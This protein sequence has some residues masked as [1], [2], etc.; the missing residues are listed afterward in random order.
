MSR[1]RYLRCLAFL[2]TVLSLLGVR[3]ASADVPDV[4]F[5]IFRLD[6]LTYSVK[7]VYQETQPYHRVLAPPGA[8]Q[9]GNVYLQ[10]KPAGDFGYTKIYSRITGQL[11]VYA[12]TIWMGRGGLIEPP[13]ASFTHDFEHGHVAPDPTSILDSSSGWKDPDPAWAAVKDTDVIERLGALGDYEVVIY[14]HFYTVGLSDP[15]TAEWFVIAF[16]HP[17]APRDV[18]ITSVVWP[19]TIVTRGVPTTPEIVVHNFSDGP[20]SPVV[21]GRAENGSG[22]VYD[23]SVPTGEIPP[24]SSVTLLLPSWVA[25]TL[26]SH[27]LTI[28]LRQGQGDPWS[29]TFNDNDQQSKTCNV[30][31]LPVFRQRP[32][33]LTAGGNPGGIPLDLDGD[34]DMDYFHVDYDT[35][36]YRNDGAQGFTDITSRFPPIQHW[37]HEA[38]ASDLNGDG[39][40]ELLVSDLY[41]GPPLLFSDAGSGVYSDIT[42]TAGLGGLDNHG[43]G[44]LLDADQDGDADLVLAH[45]LGTPGQ[46]EIVLFKNDGGHFSRLQDSGLEAH[47]AQLA[48]IVPAD[49]NHDGYP[50]LVLANW[51]SPSEVF[52]NDGTGHFSV[53][54]GPWTAVTYGRSALVFDPDL[55]GDLDILLLARY[56]SATSRYF[57]NKGGFAFVDATEAFGDLVPAFGGRVGDVDGNG[58]PDVI[59]Q[60]DKSLLL[61]EG[62]HFTAHGE[63]IIGAGLGYPIYVLD[64]DADGDLDIA[65]E[66]G[67]YLEN[68]GADPTYRAVGVHL[69]SL[70]AR[71]EGGEAVVEWSLAED[72][73]A[74]DFQV[75]RSTLSAPE[76][77]SISGIL[78]GGKRAYEFVDRNA[79]PE[80]TDYWIAEVTRTGG[81]NWFGPV[82]VEV[83]G[84]TRLSLSQ[85]SPNP[86][87]LATRIVF[88]LPERMAV[89]LSVYNVEGRK[90]RDLADQVFPPGETA[91]YWDGRDEQGRTTSSGIYY[92]RLDA[93]RQSFTHRMIKIS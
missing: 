89:K 87:G 4:H 92:Y 46:M 79:P 22:V 23:V 85:N 18:G 75:Y 13:V 86:F 9:L 20:E 15:T 28:S 24:D 73:Y 39:F 69:T 36:I 55:D 25:P 76:K 6:F 88:S 78:T 65:Y 5:A 44:R 66:R 77:R 50:D 42:S 70:T 91:V 16:T 2:L 48:N 10:V 21:N 68:L 27:T 93:G 34:G 1:H 83:A 74:S 7:G 19:Q 33:S 56:V 60:D 52:R 32:P 59:L 62:G 8:G 51:D 67:G 3:R 17:P 30:T 35:K 81:R 84:L 71:R 64:V 49:L 53:V 72:A 54:A 29:D 45:G 26:E 37:A 57:E 58:Y 14:E 90:V 47:N 63:L 31:S 12:E 40:P 38:L 80:R 41:T 43:M 11:L 61:N 82:S